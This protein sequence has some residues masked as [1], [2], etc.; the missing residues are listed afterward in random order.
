MYCLELY[1]C[2]IKTHCSCLC[3]FISRRKFLI[4]GRPRGTSLVDVFDT[5]VALVHMLHSALRP[6]QIA[7]SR[8]CRRPPS[9]RSLSARVLGQLDFTEHPRQLRA[10]VSLLSRGDQLYS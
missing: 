7:L 4:F 6:T 2:F 10:P 1:T 3:S 5:V 9:A 8:S